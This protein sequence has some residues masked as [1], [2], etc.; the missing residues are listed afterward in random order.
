[1]E[2]LSG[3]RLFWSPKPIELVVCYPHRISGLFDRFYEICV[4]QNLQKSM[5]EI[6]QFWWLR[7][8]SSMSYVLIISSFQFLIVWYLAGWR[9]R[10]QRWLW[11]IW[12]SSYHYGESNRW[13]RL[14]HLRLLQIWGG[15]KYGQQVLREGTMS[16]KW[17]IRDALTYPISLVFNLFSISQLEWKS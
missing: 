3:P 5:A 6:W 10:S 16:Q 1:M 8:R 12:D 14:L 9:W 2:L 7:E 4:L 15:P 17:S 11:D 13:R